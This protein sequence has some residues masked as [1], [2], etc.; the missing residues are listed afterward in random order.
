MSEEPQRKKQRTSRLNECIV[1]FSDPGTPYGSIGHSAINA[2]V[3][4]IA[5]SESPQQIYTTHCTHDNYV[6]IV[7]AKMNDGSIEYGMY[8]SNESGDVESIR[9]G[10]VNLCTALGRFRDIDYYF[11]TTSRHKTKRS[12]NVFDAMDV[13]LTFISGDPFYDFDDLYLDVTLTDGFIH[14][15]YNYP[16]Y[17]IHRRTNLPRYKFVE[18]KELNN[19]NTTNIH[20]DDMGVTEHDT[21]LYFGSG[22][23]ITLI[24]VAEMS[25]GDMVHGMCRSPIMDKDSIGRGF[26]KMNV[27]IEH[28]SGI[29]ENGDP[30]VIKDV[31]YYLITTPHFRVVC[32]RAVHEFNYKVDVLCPIRN[33][34]QLTRVPTIYTPVIDVKLSDGMI[35]VKYDPGT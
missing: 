26:T 35:E 18:N 14:V 33:V 10:F 9:E 12:S 20:I 34:K 19:L 15:A 25:D 7:V 16:P 29:D 31:S 28:T 23:H 22:S 8:H 27:F 17:S 30:R 21:S 32:E 5:T 11:V 13:P 3:G 4:I 2:D 1:H 6:L 24:V